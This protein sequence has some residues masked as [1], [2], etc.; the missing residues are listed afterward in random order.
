[1]GGLFLRVGVVSAA[2]LLAAPALA[3]NN[4]RQAATQGQSATPGDGGMPDA[5]PDYGDDSTVINPDGDDSGAYSD[6]DGGDNGDDQ[7]DSGGDDGDGLP[8]TNQI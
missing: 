6:D 8:P 7:D 4:H 5:A 3:D 2:V 1:M